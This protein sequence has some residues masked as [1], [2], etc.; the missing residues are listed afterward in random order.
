M[1]CLFA[2]THFFF[3]VLAGMATRQKRDCDPTSISPGL[4]TIQ[5]YEH[6][7]LKKPKNC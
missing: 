5:L 7:F 1:A 6:P 2:W 4:I 3:E